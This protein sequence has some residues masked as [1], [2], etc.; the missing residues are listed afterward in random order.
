MLALAEGESRTPADRNI[1]KDPAPEDLCDRGLFASGL[2]M[3]RYLER[4]RPDCKTT[5]LLLSRKTQTPSKH[6]L[7]CL[8]RLIRYLRSTRSLRL[9][10]KPVGNELILRASA[11]S[12]FANLPDLRSSGGWTIA[13]NPPN[14]PFASKA[15]IIKTQTTSSTHS[16]LLCGVELL[17]SLLYYHG[18]LTDMGYEIKPIKV[19]QDNTSAIRNLNT[20]P[21]GNNKSKFIGIKRNFFME[22]IRDGLI[23][24][25]YTPTG[26]ILADGLSKILAPK[27]FFAWRDRMLNIETD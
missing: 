21:S 1:L 7:E 27:G 6:D 11:D 25:E 9:R 20:G 24:L 5:N 18:M 3:T 13:L 2:G 4:T 12:A 8:Y 19:E 15:F 14:A 10:I 23:V 17:E 16:E 26:E 22:K